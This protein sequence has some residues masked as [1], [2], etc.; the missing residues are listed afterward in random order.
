MTTQEPSRIPS[1][2]I[3]K[4][5]CRANT[6][7][8]NLSFSRRIQHTLRKLL[9]SW[10]AWK[11]W[12]S[13][14][15]WWENHLLN[16]SHSMCWG[17]ILISL[18]TLL[19]HLSWNLVSAERLWI[20]IIMLSCACIAMIFSITINVLFQVQNAVDAELFWKKIS[21][22]LKELLQRRI[23]LISMHFNLTKVMTHIKKIS[24][25]F[26]ISN[27]FSLFVLFLVMSD[28]IEEEVETEEIEPSRNHINTDEIK[29][30]F[31]AARVAKQKQLE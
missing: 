11:Y 17:N 18:R 14:I 30:M 20:Q 10:I 24:F 19:P 26:I 4:R 3:A 22:L 21:F 12:S 29:S 15:M 8:V 9:K 2:S 5:A 31:E 23:Y 6:I 28:I 27:I 16:N 1:L 25:W 13:R 7:M